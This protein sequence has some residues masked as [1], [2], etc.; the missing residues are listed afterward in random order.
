MVRAVCEKCGKEVVTT[1]NNVI[2]EHHFNGRIL[3]SVIDEYGHKVL[4]QKTS[5]NYDELKERIEAKDY[6]YDYNYDVIRDAHLDSI[7]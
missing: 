2:I 7:Q 5:E 6:D 1:A 3:C 4:V